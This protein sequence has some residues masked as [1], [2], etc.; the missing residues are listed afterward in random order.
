MAKLTILGSG[1]MMP[2][3]KR[4]PSSFLL[5][6]DQAKLLIDCGHGALAR[7]AEIGVDPR[8]INGIFISHFHTDHFG[9]MGNLIH[10]RFVANLY[11]EKPHKN[12]II[13]GP[14]TIQERF[15][16]WKSIFWPEPKE[17]PL[18]EFNEGKNE[19]LIGNI[20]ITTFPIVHVRWFDSIG[21]RISHEGKSIFYPGDVGNDHG[22]DDLVNK[23]KNSDLLIIEAGYGQPTPNH[24][25]LE[26][27][28]LLKKE[29]GIKKV[30]FVHL[31][32]IAGEEERIL[33]F[34]G[35]RNDFVLAKDKMIIEL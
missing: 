23:S 34:I 21:C 11:E 35:S 15:E 16:K 31:R 8:E 25:S 33:N 18:L 29:A 17:I 30:V 7:L 20:K 26:Q 32:H 2:T 10:A 4:F 6:T 5:E 27:A 3:K 12:L 1:T 28:E 14:K 24:F 13:I 9:D 22:F 19:F